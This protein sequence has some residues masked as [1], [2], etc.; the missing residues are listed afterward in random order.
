MLVLS[1][2]WILGTTPIQL[3]EVRA[4]SR[5]NTRVLLA[6]L[7]REQSGHQAAL[8]RA[9]IFPQVRVSAGA[10]GQSAG[11][12]REVNIVPAIDPTTGNPI[13]DA[14]GNIIVQQEISDI[15]PIT[16]G[17]FSFE[18][19]VRQLLYDGGRWW[20]RIIQTGQLEDAAQRQLEEQQTVS[21]YEGVRR[22]YE[23]YRAQKQEEVLEQTLKRSRAQE[24]RSLAVFQAG[25]ASKAEHFSAQVNVGNDQVA[26]IRQRARIATA[27]TELTSWLLR[28][29]DQELRAVVPEA[30]QSAP[31]AVPSLSTAMQQA[32]DHR[33]LLRSLRELLEAAQTGVKV[34][35]APYFPSL[36]AELKYQREGPSVSPV[37]TD[38]SR[39]NTFQGQ[40]LLNWDIFSGFATNAQVRNAEAESSRARLNL[41][42]AEREIE[43]DVRRALAVLETQISAFDVTRKNR[44]IAEQSLGLAEQRF[45]VGAGSTLEVRDAQLKLTEAELSVLEGRVDVELAWADLGRVTGA[46]PTTR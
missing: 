43:L 45:Q 35:R 13:T 17:L 19:S 8:A 24:A 5:Q 32:Q 42:Q 15:P 39:Q 30:L 28:P 27:R 25:R 26:L 18:V 9:E 11:R 33:Q 23:L 7:E 1:V 2:V 36:S 4:E 3:G 29:A 40:V 38:L 16:L 20:N 46:R 14:Q 10:G 6:G 44:D 22:F 31:G 41:R 34:A 12:R 21:E 37:F